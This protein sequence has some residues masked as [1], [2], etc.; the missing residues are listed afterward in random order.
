M[1]PVEEFDDVTDILVWTVQGRDQFNNLIFNPIPEQH[2][3]RLNYTRRYIT[4]PDGK[5]LTIDLQ[6]G[7]LDDLVEES[8]IWEGTLDDLEGTSYFPPETNLFQL[9]M[10]KSSRSI[11]G[12]F[13][14]WEASAT[15]YRNTP[16]IATS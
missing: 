6:V 5:S 3:A 16:N 8:L 11:D 15:R 12:K 10:T 4:T 2:K 1:P 13:Q 14:A 9:M 7:C